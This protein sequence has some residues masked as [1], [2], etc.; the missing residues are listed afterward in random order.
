MPDDNIRAVLELDLGTLNHDAAGRGLACNGDIAVN[1]TDTRLEIN[2]PAYI[3]YD[4]T[5][6]IGCQRGAKTARARVVR[7]RHMEDDTTTSTKCVSAVAFCAGKRRYSTRTHDSCQHCHQRNPRNHCTNVSFTHGALS[8]DWIQLSLLWKNYVNSTPQR[9]KKDVQ[10]CL[11]Y[12]QFLHL[13]HIARQ[14]LQT[15]V[16]GSKSP[17]NSR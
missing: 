6:Y 8:Y 7:G 1:Y 2:G 12:V 16:S 15:S 17:V 10:L 11:F 13:M 3:K 14:S 5:R 9:I 4:R